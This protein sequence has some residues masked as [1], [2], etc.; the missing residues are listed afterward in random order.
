M[1]VATAA[2]FAGHA[3]TH[4]ILAAIINLGFVLGG[5]GLLKLR[6]WGWWL[7]VVLCGISIA[8]LLWQLFTSLRPETATR[9]NEMVSYIVAGVYLAIAFFLTSD[10]VRTTFRGT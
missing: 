4:T 8:H 7:T 1:L 5:V 6:R 9:Q 10:S 2:A 3:N